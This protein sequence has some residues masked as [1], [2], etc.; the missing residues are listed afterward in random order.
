MT[1][2]LPLL[3]KSAC[4]KQAQAGRDHH[5]LM[6]MRDRDRGTQTTKRERERWPNLYTTQ[7][8]NHPSSFVDVTLD[9]DGSCGSL[10][11]YAIYIHT[12]P[13]T[14]RDIHSQ[15]HAIYSLPKW[16]Q[17]TRPANTLAKLLI[18][19]RCYAL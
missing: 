7:T 6:E 5:F 4:R 19:F 18:G 8:S 16:N 1:V 3:L 17:F 10:L 15:V 14:G 9:S 2:S 13:L 11:I 12:V